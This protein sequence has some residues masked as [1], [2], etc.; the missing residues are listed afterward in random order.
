[1]KKTI[2]FSTGI[3]SLLIILLLA[4]V[5]CA[6]PSVIQ[7]PEIQGLSTSTSVNAV[8]LMTEADALSWQLSNLGIN[9]TLAAPGLSPI[10]CR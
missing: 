6:D 7:A 8:G 10:R 4:G 1:M 2:Y 5:V 9:S 3:I